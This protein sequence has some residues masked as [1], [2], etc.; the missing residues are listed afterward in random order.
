MDNYYDS[1]KIVNYSQCSRNFKPVFD[2]TKSEFT[3]EL[4]QSVIDSI[5]IDINPIRDG[6]G[7]IL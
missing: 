5:N 7:N 2:L 4:K 1:V 6:S 3:Y